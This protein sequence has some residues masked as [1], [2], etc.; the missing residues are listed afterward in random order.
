[1]H[2]VHSTE[3]LA[4][5]S[6]HLV[7]VVDRNTVIGDTIEPK[8]PIADAVRTAEHRDLP[9]GA[10]DLGEVR[11]CGLSRI[12]PLATL[13]GGHL[14]EVRSLDSL[15]LLDEAA[16]ED[17]LPRFPA[18]HRRNLEFIVE[19]VPVEKHLKTPQD[20]VHRTASELFIGRV[21]QP[22][23]SRTLLCRFESESRLASFAV[24]EPSPKCVQLSVELSDGGP[25]AHRP[26]IVRYGDLG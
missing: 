12:D 6:H 11:D 3:H 18:H 20:L 15:I 14:E 2:Q 24:P 8:L 4:K 25:S 21:V 5:V 17:R 22:E 7:G 23:L 26:R 9:V 13:L 10:D 19:G 16:Q 1:M